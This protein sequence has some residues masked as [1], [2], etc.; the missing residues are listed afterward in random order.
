MA[1]NIFRILDYI[2]Y[3]FVT[4]VLFIDE[5]NQTATKDDQESR[6]RLPFTKEEKRVCNKHRRRA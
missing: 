5:N 3:V 4:N 6:I 2:W 1:N